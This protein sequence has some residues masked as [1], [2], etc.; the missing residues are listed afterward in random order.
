[1]SVRGIED[2]NIDTKGLVE[3]SEYISKIKAKFGIKD[4]L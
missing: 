3:K 2:E 1:M 4:D